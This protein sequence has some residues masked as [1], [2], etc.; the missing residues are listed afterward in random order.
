MRYSA[1]WETIV[2]RFGRWIDFKNDYKTMDT[3]YMESVWYVF[4]QMY[5]KGLV[6]KGSK[7]MPY[8][9]K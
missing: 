7:V 2:K 9:T 8:S 1:Q 3:S 5:D 4:K 6:Y